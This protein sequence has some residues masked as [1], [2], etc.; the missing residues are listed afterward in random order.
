[1]TAAASD[2]RAASA[3]VPISVVHRL[4]PVEVQEQQRQRTAAARRALR[5]AVQHLVQVARVVE[6]RQVVGD[7]Q[8]LDATQVQQRVERKRWPLQDDTQRRGQFRGQARLFRRRRRI[9][10]DAGRRW[11]ARGQSAG[12]R[13]QWPAARP[14]GTR[15]SFARLAV[16]N[17]SLCSA[18]HSATP[19]RASSYGSQGPRRAMMSGCRR[20]VLNR[21]DQTVGGKP[22]GRLTEQRIAHLGRIERAVDRSNQFNE[23]VSAI[24]PVL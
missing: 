21:D 23:R 7:R 11:S 20:P 18:I 16:T 5:F 17:S 22:L 2:E 15:W 6:A 19:A 4:E 13:R 14:A 3:Q 10:R 12:S 1:M 9:E 8:R 24:Q